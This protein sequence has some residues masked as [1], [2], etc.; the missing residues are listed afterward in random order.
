MAG[1]AGLTHNDGG[2]ERNAL[3]EHRAGGVDEETLRPAGLSKLL[4]RTAFEGVEIMGPAAD[5]GEVRDEAESDV[6]KVG[7]EGLAKFDGEGGRDRDGARDLAVAME[8]LGAA[9]GR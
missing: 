5:E 6:A 4:K 1:D 7:A 3:V 2:G 8:R 9:F